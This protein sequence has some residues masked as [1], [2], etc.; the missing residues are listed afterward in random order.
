M[1]AGEILKNFR[2]KLNMSQTDFAARMGFS[3]ELL[4]TLENDK[5]P[6]TTKTKKLLIKEFKFDIDSNILQDDG[7][8]AE[9]K[10]KHSEAAKEIKLLWEQ[11][12]NQQATLNVILMEVESLSAQRSGKTVSAVSAELRRTIKGETDRLFDLYEKRLR[13]A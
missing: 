7:G 2:E 6:I 1:A 12:I 13:L 10:T 5:A 11:S 3:R 9:Y 8:G 4:S